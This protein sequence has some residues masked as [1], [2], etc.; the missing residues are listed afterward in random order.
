MVTINM[1]VCK[2][3]ECSKFKQS[4]IDSTRYLCLYIRPF[5]F[6]FELIKE[7]EEQEVP[8]NCPFKSE[9]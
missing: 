5:Q 9:H 4:K 2:E 7:Y 6:Q 3:N 1:S 8:D